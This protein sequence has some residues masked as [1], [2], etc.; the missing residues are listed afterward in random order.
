M[1]SLHLSFHRLVRRNIPQLSAEELNHYDSLIALRHQLLLEKSLQPPANHV[2]LG[3]KRSNQ[4]HHPR[5]EPPHPE[6][7]QND[8]IDGVSRQANDILRPYK[9][10]Y[11]ASVRLW[12]ARRR[13]ATRLGNSLQIPDTGMSL[14]YLIVA[15]LNYYVVAAVTFPIFAWN[16]IKFYYKEIIAIAV[17]LALLGF[18]FRALIPP[19]QRRKPDAGNG[20]VQPDS[21]MNQPPARADALK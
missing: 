2:E 11:E 18:G 10:A 1:T 3:G 13:V 12:I 19:D 21:T 9:R 14:F 7:D 5:H 4:P 6:P 8:F 20:I 15:F 16:W 17:L